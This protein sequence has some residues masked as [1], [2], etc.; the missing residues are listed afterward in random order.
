MR[1]G[2]ADGFPVSEINDM[3]ATAEGV[4]PRCRQSRQS[5]PQAFLPSD[6]P[7]RQWRPGPV[8]DDPGHASYGTIQKARF[9]AP[10]KGYEKHLFVVI[11]STVGKRVGFART[12]PYE[13]PALIICRKHGRRICF[14]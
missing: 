12:Q 8:Q 3:R 5:F 2:P 7:K 11:G 1:A 4:H 14:S 13:N 10:R 6:D 9:L